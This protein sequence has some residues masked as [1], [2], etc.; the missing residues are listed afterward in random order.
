MAS[1][2]L[3]EFVDEESTTI[4]DTDESLPAAAIITPTTTDHP[5]PVKTNFDSADMTSGRMT[6]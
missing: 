1:W 4:A 6:S 5:I 3:L 2:W